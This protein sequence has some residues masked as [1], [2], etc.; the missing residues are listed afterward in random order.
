[1]GAAQQQGNTVVQL[2]DRANVQQLQYAAQPHLGGNIDI[3][4]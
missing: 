1:M 4:V 2:M 3:S